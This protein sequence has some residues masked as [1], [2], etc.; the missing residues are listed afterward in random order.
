MNTKT[1]AQEARK[2]LIQGVAKKLLYWGFNEKGETLE[3]PEKASGGY[4]FRNQVF[5]DPSVPDLWKSLQTSIENKGIDV[6]VEEAAY[7]W[8]NRIMAL[9]ILV[10]NGYEEPQLENATGL[11]HTPVIL[12]KARQG[13]IAFLTADKKKSLQK[14]L[15]D[16][17]KDQEAFAI[18]IKGYCHNHKTL[19]RVFGKIDDYTEL[20]LPDNMLQA[21]GFLHLLNT[22]DA[23]SDEEYQKVELIGWLYQFYIS[24]KKDEVFASFK[25][26]KKAEAKDIPAATQIFTPNWIVKYMVENTAG[27]IWLDKN[28]NSNLKNDMKYLVANQSEATATPIIS[29]IEELTLIDPAAGSGHILVEGFDLIYKMYLE[30]YYTP[31]EAVESILKNNLYGLDI[32]D[33]AA[34]LA[35][36][37][38]LL[39][40]AKVYPAIWSKNWLPNVYEMPESEEFST[41]EIKDF[42]GDKGTNY[43]EELETALCLMK[44]AKNLGSVMKL[45]LSE[46]A[47]TFI[48]QRF[49]TLKTA[50]FRDLTLEFI[51]QKIK[52]YIPVLLILTKKYTSVVANPPYMGQK[53]MNVDLKNYVNA[54]Y[55][56]TKSD[57]MTIFMEVIPNL[58]QDD[59][60][61]AL[62]NLPS[63]LF[64]SSFE[65]IRKS[66]IDNF[67]F[68]SLLHMGRGIFGIDFGSVAFAI[69]KTKSENAIGSYFRLHERNFQHVLYKD[70]EKLFLYSNGKEN[71][72]YDF[73]QYRGEE[74]ITEI[75]ENG[76]LEGKKLFYPNTPQTNFSKIPGSPIAYWVSEMTNKLFST[77]PLLKE[78]AVSD[79]KN[80]TGDNAKYVKFI[81]EVSKLNTG[82]DKK[83]KEYT[84]GGKYRKW[85]G[86]V[87][88]VINWSDEARLHFR[89]SNVG[90]LIPEYLWDKPGISW[91]WVASG[92][93]SFR[94]LNDKDMFDAGAPTIFIDNNIQRTN[95]LGLLNSRV[96]EHF[97]KLLNPTVNFP[98]RYIQSVPY[99]SS[100]ETNSITL[101]NV[102]L[103]KNNWD[104][105]ET[106]WDFEQSPLL[107]TTNSLEE[108]F[109]T[110]QKE[111][112]KDFFQLHKNEEELNR[113]FIDIYG[114][115]DELTPEVALKD[116]TILQEELAKKDLEKLEEIFNNNGKEA[117][118]LP[119]NQSEVI[120]QFISYAI[121]LF[122]GR[123]R[124]DKKGL[125]IAHPNPSEQE[126]ESYS[127]NNGEVIIDEDAIIPL[128]GTACNF[129]DDGLQQIYSLLDTLWGAETRTENI[130]FIQECL[131]KDLEQFLVT[132]F[133][134]YHCKMYKKKPIYWLFSSKKGAFKVLVYMHRMNAFTVEKIRDNYLLEHIK[135][136]AS[137]ITFL[138]NNE[139]NLNTQDRKKLEQLRKNLQEC[140]DYEA[141]LKT[142]ADNQITFD[143]DDGVT[144]NY[145]KFE[146]IIAKIK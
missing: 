41:Q 54:N 77:Q 101:D 8:F 122:M 45:T 17:S 75:P 63:W 137:E 27:K 19:Q 26:G 71:Y 119:I 68:D 29:T 46:E 47:R 88:H 50:E 144:V 118:R 99:I 80:V 4:S 123:Y 102:S 16:Y 112:T 39:K 146:T 82:L 138:E 113:I 94:T 70:I 121:G 66:Y 132:D 139:A 15:T 131:N 44:Q 133:Y 92:A 140:Y 53:S 32:D 64:L 18:L 143:L 90:R 129:P 89:K 86:N 62:I 56:L 14:I 96:S 130:N 98:P 97:L 136:V 72:K 33:R 20:L 23:I 95:V 142:V 40:S 48:E 5:D 128:M 30:E 106:S 141:A 2:I 51:Y 52:N 35:T 57:L 107:N 58:T 116:I 91:N 69:K 73:N 37:A 127:Y 111:V 114:L 108:A 67:T 115:Q 84:K 74:G 93:P 135:N 100:K 28:P 65:K 104:S 43:L 22:T 126:L 3:Q 42:L 103:S 6:I 9:R 36:F 109:T 38:I 31:E 105:R 24:E 120:S 87:E 60:R 11:E 13:K 110:W 79:G 49:I 1:F 25:K 85:Y 10:K 59:S 21:D 81:W 55:P 61:F 124:L 12:Q 34:Q 117:V 134:K 7:T 125:N 145:K 76:T 83:W 78:Y